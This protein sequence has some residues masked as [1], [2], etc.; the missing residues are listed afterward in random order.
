MTWL[1]LEPVPVTL[2]LEPLLFGVIPQSVVPVIMMLLV[3]V[4]V[5]LMIAPYLVRYLDSIVAPLNQE[6]TGGK[7]E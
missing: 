2:I 3:G 7:R 4:G 5:A 6:G 1:R